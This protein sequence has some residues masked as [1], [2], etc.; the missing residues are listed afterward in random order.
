MGH[1]ATHVWFLDTVHPVL[2]QRLTAAG[3]RCH[4]GTRLTREDLLHPQNLPHPV[5][6][7][8]LRSRLL[9]DAAT[10]EAL[11]K[12]RWIARSGSGLENIDLEAARARGVAVHN[13]PEGNRVAVGEHTVGML[14]ALLNHFRSGDASIRN[15]QWQREAH[16]GRELQSL[17]VGICGYGQ[18][19]S[20]FAERLAG[21][22]CRVVAYDKYLAGWGDAP[23][24]PRPL[25]HVEPVG[26]A[27]LR[28]HADVVSLHLPWTA[29]TRGLVNDAW[30]AGFERS[31][32]L[33]N[34]S[35]GPIVDTA[36]LLRAL[37]DGRVVHAG[38]DVLEF[39]GR[40]LEGLDGLS[41]DGSRQTFEALL[42]HPR[43]LLTPHVAG[44]THESLVKLST[45]LA[46]KILGT[47]ST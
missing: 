40:S 37:N 47:A 45:V 38:L 12:L 21:F 43:V 44:W 10:L 24:A 7:L 14:L 9:L 32:I 19:G 27:E 31:V 39:E 25:P 13:S 22:G 41:D 42:A 33:L 34:T 4:D 1:E 30:L 26:E 36:A 6:A 18:M 5:E 20:A 2:A 8:V 3:M 35:R 29:E 16:R 15:R 23:T 28:R 17:T 11:P 46:D